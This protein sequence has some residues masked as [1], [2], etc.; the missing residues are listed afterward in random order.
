VY[1]PTGEAEVKKRRPRMAAD[2]HLSDSPG[3]IA[4]I[5]VETRAPTLFHI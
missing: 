5:A 3:E 4:N 1:L 2:H